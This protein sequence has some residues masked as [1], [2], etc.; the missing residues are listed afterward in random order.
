MVMA[1]DLDSLL[2]ELELR[3]PTWVN[4]RAA[5]TPGDAARGEQFLTEL[6]DED[7]HLCAL[8]YGIGLDLGG[9]AASLRIDPAVVSWRLQRLMNRYDNGQSLTVEA[10]LALALRG[11]DGHGEAALTIVRALP[12][13]LRQRLASRLRYSTGAL[14]STPARS[15]L[16]I[17]VLFVVLA[18]AMGFMVYGAVLDINP[19]WRGQDLLRRGKLTQARAA[20]SELGAKPDARL[21]IAISWLTEGE[22]DRALEELD[23]PEVAAW[24]GDFQPVDLP[25]PALDADPASGALLPRG[26]ILERRPTF[27]YRVGTPGT[28]QIETSQWDR[29]AQVDLPPGTPG[30]VAEVVFAGRLPDLRPGVVQWQVPGTEG[31]P[32]QHAAFEVVN[33]MSRS[34]INRE[35]N[36]RLEGVPKHAQ[37]FL[38]GHYM[39]RRGLYETAGHQFA[40]LTRRFPAQAYP[41]QMID[42][43]AGAMGIDPTVFLR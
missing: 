24:L 12:D 5:K 38:R 3:E 20:F 19:M 23:S 2:T 41:L 22:Y 25:L 33:K 29:A 26:L 8:V 43:I 37:P 28:L 39:L 34:A 21:W 40:A 35:V 10:S 11:A 16:G 7:R 36:K 15:G 14:P 4:P 42:E 13:D 32:P 18:V 1:D 31:E 17:G 9:A 6:D 27:V 30:A